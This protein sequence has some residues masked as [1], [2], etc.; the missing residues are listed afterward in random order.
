MNLTRL[1][2]QPPS[3]ALVN[4]SVHNSF[5]KTTRRLL[6]R[7]FRPSLRGCLRGRSGPDDFA[8]MLAAYGK[9]IRAH[10]KL[11][12]LAPSFFDAAVVDRERENRAEKQ[13]WMALWEPVIS[14]VYGV[15]PTPPDPLADLPRL[16]HPNTQR[17]VERQWV[18]VQ[19]WLEAGTVA[20]QRHQQR[21]PHAVPSLSRLARLLKL[22]F[23]FKCLALGLNSPNR[24]PDKIT[25]DYEF[26][27]L[28]RSYGHLL[29]PAPSAAGGAIASGAA[30][31]GPGDSHLASRTSIP[32]DAQAS[33][34]PSTEPAALSPP[35]P[36]RCDA[37]RR[38]ARQM[39]RRG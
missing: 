9:A 29:D 15:D 24:I 34:A 37:W 39:R 2:P 17:A 35:A 19:L 11:A 28:K 3:I 18:E 14:K 6:R 12:R 31:N 4:L 27:N 1:T 32:A 10:R 23:D 36:P 16:P 5:R 22:A 30:S 33:T 38:L 7:P 26:T 8:Q 25:Y 20:R 21:R 13:K